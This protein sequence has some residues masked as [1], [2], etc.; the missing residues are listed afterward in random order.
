VQD[1]AVE[2][3]ALPFHG[4]SSR[5]GRTLAGQHLLDALSAADVICLA[6]DHGNAH[7]HW[8]GLR[9]LDSLVEHAQTSGREVALGMETFAKP[10]QEV[11]DRYLNRKG[12]TER[13]LLE[14]TEWNRPPSHDYALFRP[15]VLA[16]RAY[17][18]PVLAL[19]APRELTQQVAKA[20]VDSLS[21]DQRKRL[22]Q[23]AL[24][25]AEHRA[26]FD[27]GRGEQPAA[28]EEQA[29]AAYV[30]CDETMA[31]TAAAWLAERQPARQLLIVAAADHCRAPAIPGRIQRRTPSR[32]VSVRPVLLDTGVD[33][34]AVLERYDYAIVLGRDH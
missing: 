1:D 25:D 19:N 11:L 17:D 2:R 14:A 16:A 34:E 21:E 4:A 13:E 3:S 31:E 26:L 30:L 7:H 24:D 8:A 10:A 6:E 22:P 29:Y 28:A 5:D 20:G 33:L 9:I 12:A 32:V 15:L 18:L 27:A 23:L